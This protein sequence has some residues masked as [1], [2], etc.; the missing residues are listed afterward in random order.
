MPRAQPT[1]SDVRPHRR[2]DGVEIDSIDRAILDCLRANA[3]VPLKTI[4]GRVGLA[5]SSASERIARLEAARVI[6]GYRAIVDDEATGSIGAVVQVELART[7]APDVVAA[8]VAM[9]E[10]VRCYSLSGAIDLLVELGA[11]DTGTLNATR[12]AIGQLPGVTRVTT[13][14]ILK[15]DKAGE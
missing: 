15:R 12:D 5:H 4:A 14:L 1:P 6:R 10:V 7:P 11:R 9:P 13:A 2:F 8:I 3:R